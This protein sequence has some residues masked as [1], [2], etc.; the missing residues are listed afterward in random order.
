MHKETS[1]AVF[2]EG[3]HIIYKFS[4]LHYSTVKNFNSIEFEFIV[5]FVLNN[6]ATYGHTSCVSV[7]TLRSGQSH[8]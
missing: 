3:A 6:V 1:T 7:K 4:S 2:K 5:K 8:V